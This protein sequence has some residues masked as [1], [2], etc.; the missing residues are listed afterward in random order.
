MAALNDPYTAKLA[1]LRAA[2]QPGVDPMAHFKKVIKSPSVRLRFQP[3]TTLEVQQILASMK[4]TKSMVVN[5]I[6]VDMV[7]RHSA[8]L[9]G[10]VANLINTS[11]A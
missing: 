11:L 7:M 3:I 6:S 4:L 8:I 5:R 1:N 10:P 2:M 9:A